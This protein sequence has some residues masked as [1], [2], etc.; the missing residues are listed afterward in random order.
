MVRKLNTKILKGLTLIIIVW[1]FGVV[2][3]ALL[4][5]NSGIGL[6]GMSA[7]KPL[8]EYSSVEKLAE[9][10]DLDF[11]IPDFILFYEDID[12]CYQ[13]ADGSVNITG[14]RFNLHI[15]KTMII[16]DKII[17]NINIADTSDNLSFNK[18]YAV[19]NNELGIKYMKYQIGDNYTAISWFTDDLSYGLKLFMFDGVNGRDSLIKSVGIDPKTMKEIS[20]TEESDD[21]EIKYK[22]YI[23]NDLGIKINLPE[24]VDKELITVVESIK[25]GDKND[26]VCICNFTLSKYR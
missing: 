12:K 16:D 24:L 6:E 18:T 2:A 11:K 19:D 1:L 15:T 9:N 7:I 22:E 23:F 25:A 10:S 26:K 17:T 21:S 14:E 4:G 3:I 8:H 5:L 20:T 13:Y